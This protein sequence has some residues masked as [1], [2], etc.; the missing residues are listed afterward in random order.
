MN[1][2][3]ESIFAYLP[4]ISL[5]L[6]LLLAFAIIIIFY[7]RAKVKQAN[8]S[9]DLM[10]VKFDLLLGITNPN[11]S[12]RVLKFDLVNQVCSKYM[13]EIGGWLTQFF[14]TKFLAGGNCRSIGKLI[15][16]FKCEETKREVLYFFNL[17]LDH[18]KPSDLAGFLIN[19]VSDGALLSDESKERGWNL[20]GKTY[21][22]NY[23]CNLGTDQHV[24]LV[25]EFRILSQDII[26]DDN[27]ALKVEVYDILRR[28]EKN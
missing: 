6:T 23:I 18:M 17:A 7:E 13:N 11:P 16:S 21:I 2:F 3:F 4:E 20:V 9:A 19:S 22:C 5:L 15:S 24:R 1:N 10:K 25:E 14:I 8:K 12:N 26:N 27:N 28:I